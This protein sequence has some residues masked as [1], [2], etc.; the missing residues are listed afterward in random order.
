MPRVRLLLVAFLLIGANASVV[1]RAS[2]AEWPAARQFVL[3]E[4]PPRLGLYPP[5]SS[6]AEDADGALLALVYWPVTETSDGSTTEWP[7]TRLVRIAPD[8]AR[9]FVPPF[10]EL[11]PGSLDTRINVDD[12]ILPLP[13]GSILFTRYNAIDRLRPDG[14]IGRFAGTGRYS[15]DSSGDGGPATVADIGFAHGLS[16]FPDGSIVFADRSRVRRVASDG[17]ITTV[18]GSGEDGFGGDGGPATAALLRSPSDVLPTDDGGFLIADTYSGRVRRVSAHGVISTVAGTDKSDI[19]ESFGDGGPATA[20][21]LA[22]PQHL[23]RL[24]DGSLLIGEW[25]R[26]RQVSPDGTISTIFQVQQVHANRLGDFAGRYGESI[27]AMDVT[28]EGGIAIIASGFRLRALYLAPRRT[29]RTLV[30]LRD[31]R[32]SQ[33]RVKVTVHTTTPGRLRLQVRRRGRVV[34]NATRRVRSRRHTIGVRGRFAAAYH[35]VRVTLRADRGGGSRDR[36]RLFTSSTLPERL[37]VPALGSDVRACKRIDRR[38]IDC[39]T[40]NPEDE[41]S[42]RSCLNTRANRL[43][44]SGLLFTRAYGPRC[45]RKPIRFDRTPNWSGPWQAWPPR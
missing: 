39:E 26:I 38:R 17:I 19:F 30:A 28:Q 7:R 1:S 40:H 2:S 29:Q 44:P 11:E 35:D 6:V 10:G 14:S 34:A 3:V 41:E 16:R 43:F 13:D 4:P 42:G 37:V 21:G 24:P 25:Q 20:A 15:E 18:A 36:I 8:G 12:E 32:A 27:E 22:L 33:R 9:A 45:H 5:P 31:A 23:A